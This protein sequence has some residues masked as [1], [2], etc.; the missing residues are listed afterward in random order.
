M[1]RLNREHQIWAPLGI[2]INWHDGLNIRFPVSERSFHL[3]VTALNNGAVVWDC[4]VPPIAQQERIYRTAQTYNIPW[5]VEI[6]RADGQ[7]LFFWRADLAG[8][9]VCLRFLTE[10]LGDVIAWMAVADRFHRIYN[11]WMTIQMKREFIP[12]FAA[13]RPRFHFIEEA[14]FK[15]ADYD[16]VFP[17]WPS[18]ET[19]FAPVP[20]SRVNPFAYA[21]NLLAADNP[22]EIPALVEQP[23]TVSRPAG[24]YVCLMPGKGD[25]ELCGMKTAEWE[26]VAAFLRENGYETVRL[27][28]TAPFLE[29]LSLLQGAQFAIGVMT[30]LLW[31]A[32]ASKKNAVQLVGTEHENQIPASEFR[33]TRPGNGTGSAGDAITSEEVIGVI[34]TVPVFLE[35]YRK[36][37][38]L[39][40][41]VDF[42]VLVPVHNGEKTLKRCL[43]SILNQT[44]GNFELIVCN[45]G[46]TDNT[47]AILDAYAKQD[48]R[49][50]LLNHPVNQGRMV[51]RRELAQAATKAYTV[52]VDCDDEIAPDYLETAS[53]ALAGKDCDIAALRCELR[54][55]Y[56]GIR[57]APVRGCIVRG[58]S[59]LSVYLKN[60]AYQGALWGK[61]FR[62]SLLKKAVPTGFD[63]LLQEDMFFMLPLYEQARSFLYVPSARPMYIYYGDTGEWSSKLHNM[64]P[65]LFEEYCRLKCTQITFAADYFATHGYGEGTL[66]KYV[67]DMCEWTTIM[68]ILSNYPAWRKQGIEIFLKWFC[69][70][71]DCLL[72]DGKVKLPEVATALRRQIDAI[73]GK[74]GTAS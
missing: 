35:E 50:R 58:D 18:E 11:C 22:L 62:T 7:R 1:D 74:A 12:L 37:H 41:S 45:D 38:P 55:A 53:R 13:I 28:D 44:C 63:K 68:S 6:R 4:D 48:R 29:N 36:N 31:L 49:V 64:T 25:T 16:A 70:E 23:A 65:E 54:L 33:V 24:K 56:S 57:R 43:D 52:W 60:D 73:A 27:D 42:S 69:K 72:N 34:K 66:K 21:Q 15:A 26:A 67:L 19:K 10:S 30:P 9:D 51:T 46:S 3:K 61:A 71:P 40:N 2:R 14:A 39:D 20:Y 5:Q 32:W 8:R 47:Q 59:M 17:L